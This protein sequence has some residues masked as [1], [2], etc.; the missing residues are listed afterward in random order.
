MTNLD[1]ILKSRDITLPTKVHLVKAMAFP[2]VMKRWELD[3]KGDWTPKNW[4]FWTVDM[5]KTLESPLDF[6]EIKPVNPEGNQSWIFSGRT[7]AEVETSILW[8]PDTK[9]WLIWKDWC[10]GRLKAGGEGY[11]RMRWLDGITNSMDVSLSKLRELVM[12]REAWVL[13]ST[14]LQRVRYDWATELN[15]SD[16]DCYIITSGELQTK[17]LQHTQKRKHNTK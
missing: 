9:N 3:H 5:E 8:P 11:D 6:K 2:V 14:G 17:K 7:D 13:Q 1:S 15:W 12:D 16:I 10:W 4:C